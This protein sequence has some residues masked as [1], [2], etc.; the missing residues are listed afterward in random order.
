MTSMKS[1]MSTIDWG[2]WIYEDW[3][4]SICGSTQRTSIVPQSRIYHSQLAVG[5]HKL[6]DKGKGELLLSLNDELFCLK[7]E[8]LRTYIGKRS[9][10]GNFRMCCDYI[11]TSIHNSSTFVAVDLTSTV[12]TTTD[13]LKTK[14]DQKTGYTKF[15]KVPRQLE[16]SIRAL[17]LC[18]NIK[19]FINIP[20]TP[21]RLA[22]CS[23]QLGDKIYNTER[24]IYP[25]DGFLRVLQSEG[26]KVEYPDKGLNDLGFRYFRIKSTYRIEL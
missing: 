13:I 3:Y 12:Y 19:T 10:L 6:T 17:S 23:Y 2:K 5:N 21:H 15:E 1:T 22:I 16:S 7:Y 14:Q 11:L 24:E 9:A 26:E 20:R 4:A 25:E 18:S 8:E